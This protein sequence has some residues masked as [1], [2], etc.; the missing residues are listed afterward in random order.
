MTSRQNIPQE[1]KPGNNQSAIDTRN[2]QLAE[3]LDTDGIVN[4][5]RFITDQREYIL[6]YLDPSYFF[7]LYHKL[8]IADALQ[9][10]YRRETL[11]C[12]LKE[13]DDRDDKETY[14]CFLEILKKEIQ[15]MGHKC[16][17]AMFEQKPF[18]NE[19][20]IQQ[21]EEIAER[22]VENMSRVEEMLDIDSNMRGLLHEVGLITD[23]EFE[24]LSSKSSTRRKTVQSFEILLSTKGSTAHYIFLKNV[25]S[26][27]SEPRAKE[28]YK[29]LTPSRKRRVST[30]VEDDTNFSITKRHVQSLKASKGV[31][32]SL[33]VHIFR[34]VRKYDQIGECERRLSDDLLM[35]LISCSGTPMDVKIAAL[36]ESSSKLCY[37]KDKKDEVCS[38]V[39]TAREMCIQLHR[40]EE[41]SQA[42]EGL[43]EWILAKLYR[44]TGD[45]D[46]ALRHVSIAYQL[47]A[48]CEPGE[49]HMLVSYCHGCILQDIE[50]ENFKN[51]DCVLEL[52]DKSISYANVEDYGLRIFSHATVRKAQK[53]L[54]VS[55]NNPETKG[56]GLTQES[57]ENAQALL[58]SATV[59]ATEPRTQCFIDYTRSDLH[60]LSGNTEQAK[61]HF[62]NSLELATAYKLPFE[63][64]ALSKREHLIVSL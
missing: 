46:R 47:I 22:M 26:K 35:E 62:K 21:S 63:K 1:L 40:E 34:V 45:Y 27:C 42:L 14:V 48:H 30:M 57:L 11:K 49:V 16:L 19:H 13:M 51:R 5:K 60:R 33:Y 2:I 29:E 37:E 17:F 53:Y 36:L 39:E 54:G 6:K 38:R 59:T 3:C 10:S 8:N 50:R 7:K 4:I 44:C 61:H 25:L 31:R 28:L 32:M 23:D 55:S 24:N 56:G 41:N 12:L 43:C 64:N 18:A 9:S 15:H 52:F 58:D 20:M